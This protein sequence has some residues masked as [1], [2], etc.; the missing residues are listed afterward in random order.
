MCKNWGKDYLESENFN[1]SCTTHKFEWGGQMYWCWG[2]T[3][4]DAKGCILKKHES[5]EDEDDFKEQENENF[6]IKRQKCQCCKSIGHLAKD[7]YRDPNFRTEHGVADEDLR[8]NGLED[9]ITKR[10]MKD[11][12]MQSIEVSIH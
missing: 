7:W 2:K 9:L 11:A 3:N 1:W 12:T 10:H 4:R 6:K 8:V 5:K